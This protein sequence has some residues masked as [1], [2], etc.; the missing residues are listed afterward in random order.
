M[1]DGVACVDDISET[2][3]EGSDVATSPTT[4]T[5]PEY[6]DEDVLTTMDQRSAALDVQRPTRLRSQSTES[7]AS[8]HDE[9]DRLNC[10]HSPVA[11]TVTR[12]THDD[13]RLNNTAA[14]MDVAAVQ[15]MFAESVL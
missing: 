1:P 8:D 11:M 3:C 15:Q 4:V 9:Y 2:Q 7:T 5:N 6:F 13:V 14:R 10:S 12:P